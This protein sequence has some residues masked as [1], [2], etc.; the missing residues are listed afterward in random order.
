MPVFG[1]TALDSR[2]RGND[3]CGALRMTVEKTGM[4]VA[5]LVQVY[6]IAGGLA[7]TGHGNI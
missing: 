5:G 1:R 3:G 2:L 6:T 7:E 4:T